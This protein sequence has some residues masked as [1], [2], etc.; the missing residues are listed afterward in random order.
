MR[1]S[2]HSFTTDSIDAPD[3]LDQ[4]KALTL[5]AVAAASWCARGTAEAQSG[6]LM[7]E[8]LMLA[9][10]WASRARRHHGL[11]ALGVSD[12]LSA[13]EEPVVR[14]LPNA[15]TF[16]LVED[17]VP[18]PICQDLSDDA[19]PSPLAEVEQHVIRAAMN[20]L[21]GREDEAVAYTAFRR[22]LVEHAHAER[23]E[24]AAAVQNVGVELGRVYQ[25]V[26]AA[27]V[28]QRVGEPM[29]YPCPRCHWPMNVQGTVVS[30]HRSVTCLAA[31]ARFD[32]SDEHLVGLGG[33][34]P[35]APMPEQ[36]M[37]SLRP[38]VWRFT[39][40]PGLEE[41]DLARRLGSIGGVEIQLWPFVDA[42]DLDVRRG[43]HHWRVDVKDHSSAVS[44]ARH[45]NERPRRE[46][47]WIVVPDARR[48]QIP[49]LLR[50][51]E[52]DAGYRF[53]SASEIVRR[54]KE[55]M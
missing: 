5:A 11:P 55:A 13:F 8:R 53:A 10:S 52:S 33:L 38:G 23:S 19:G 9:A 50:Q 22:F 26:P 21:L 41:L 28:V 43:D 42:Y 47:I 12:L 32:L 48:E 16:T 35:P 37:A 51:A 36:G 30:C 4:E 3:S 44:L 40:L 7:V 31:G 49:V 15:G 6:R 14:W 39:V 27:S 2:E 46:P 29:F 1:G 25:R 45:L 17:G 18:T 24:A 20:H 54:V 34:T